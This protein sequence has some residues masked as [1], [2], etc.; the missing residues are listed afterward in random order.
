MPRIFIVWNQILG[1]MC[2]QKKLTCF[3]KSEISK[4]LSGKIEQFRFL[5]VEC[6]LLNDLVIILPKCPC[7]PTYCISSISETNK[8]FAKQFKDCFEWGMVV[9]T[10]NPREAEE[11]GS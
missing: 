3:L 1:P 10:C 11:G 7:G 9:C 2:P 8:S 6:Y 5:S 4:F